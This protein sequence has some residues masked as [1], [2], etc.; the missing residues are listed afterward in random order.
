[1]KRMKTPP[2][3][4]HSPPLPL[5]LNRSFFCLS[6][7]RLYW[8]LVGWRFGHPRAASSTVLCIAEII[9][10]I[11]KVIRTQGLCEYVYVF[12]CTYI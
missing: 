6:F 12:V 2:A 9:D 3:P 1:M 8:V 4:A 10:G 11:E 5:H 7:I